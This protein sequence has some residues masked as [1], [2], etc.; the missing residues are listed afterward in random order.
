MSAFKQSY[1][2]MRKRYILTKKIVENQLIVK[3]RV[4]SQLNGLLLMTELKR[5]DT[6]RELNK[7][8]EGLENN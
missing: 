5:N 2:S 1:L 3:E 7:K 8:L 4:A 6:F